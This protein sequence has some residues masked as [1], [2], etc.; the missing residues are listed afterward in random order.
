MKILMRKIVFI[1]LFVSLAIKVESQD[2]RLTFQFKQIL[3]KDLADT[4]EKTVPV[5][6]FYTDKWVDSLSLNVNSDN[7]PLDV[8]FDKS[9]SKSGLSFIITE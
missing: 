9:I 1:I 3:F 2:N 5:K 6:I 7:E 8:L 4:I